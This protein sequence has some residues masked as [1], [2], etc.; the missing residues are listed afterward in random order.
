LA[1]GLGVGYA[2]GYYAGS[3]STHPSTTL[4]ID[5]AGTLQVPF[6]AIVNDIVRP[7]YSTLSYNYIFEGSRLAANEITQANK[8]FDIFA[9]AD[10][11]IIPQQL[12]PSHASWYII[13]ASN[14]MSVVYTNHSKFANEIN[15]DN[16][17][18]IITRPG[19][20]VG[21]S[22]KETDPSGSQAIM[23]LQ[24]A[25]L[26]NYQNASYLYDQLYVTK[27]ANHELIIV[28]T[29]TTLDAQ[30]ETGAVDYVLTY[31]SEAISHK[32]QYLQ[33][34]SKVDLSDLAQAE[35]YA[36]AN[37]TVNGKSLTGAPILYDITIPNNSPD[38]PMATAFIKTLFSSQGQ[39][40]LQTSGLRPL[41][42]V[43]IYN[44]SGV[45]ADILQALTQAGIGIKEAS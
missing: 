44:Q 32:F 30:L 45:P 35:W 6:N 33:L 12:I 7:E 22:N 4:L 40:I 31:S 9:S 2:L 16:W 21:V 26:L 28:P 25:G 17:Y 36:K 14:A 1:V 41:N 10:Y 11:R 8:S 43:F 38:M 27:S 18:Q 29:E 39:A 42:P 19:V 20:V 5:A 34:N 3:S 13:F 37:T 23:M 24:L 15:S